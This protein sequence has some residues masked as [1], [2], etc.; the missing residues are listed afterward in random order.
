VPIVF[1]P[2]RMERT[3]TAKNDSPPL[4]VDIVDGGLM[5]NFPISVFHR[6]DAEKV[7]KWEPEAE[8]EKRVDGFYLAP[9]L[10]TFG[11][12][13]LSGKDRPNK[14]DGPLKLFKALIS[15]MLD[16][17][18]KDFIA[19]NPDYRL[20]VTKIDLTEIEPFKSSDS[21]LEA[22]NLYLS[23]EERISL[24][25]L[26]YVKGKEFLK[27]FDWYGYKNLRRDMAPEWDKSRESGK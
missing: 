27:G 23:K 1:E 2:V 24:F 8:Q 14:T 11:V 26:G 10:P 3:P 7:G 20:V 5:S 15:S 13:L 12:Q 25:V 6:Q 18:D 22:F 4:F 9:R 19:T 17:G 16:V 21:G